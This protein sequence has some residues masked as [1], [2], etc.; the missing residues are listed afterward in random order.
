VNTKNVQE[1]S[2][3]VPR[4]LP[5]TDVRYWQRVLFQATYTHS[6]EIRHA[7]HWSVKLQYQGRRMTFA[8]GTPNK[9]SAASRARNIYLSLQGAGWPATLAKFKPNAADTGGGAEIATVGEFIAGVK[10]K[11]SV[12][13]RTLEG[14]AQAFR[15]IVADVQRIDGGKAKY[16]AIKGG[17]QKWLDQINIVSLAAIT[18]DLVQEWKL[19]FIR[20][21]GESPARQRSARTSANTILR[22]ARSLFSPKLLKFV[23]VR[24]PEPLPFAGVQFEPRSSMRYRSEVDAPAL[25]AAARSELQ[26]DHAEQFK[27]FLLGIMAGLRR[28]EIDLLEWS[29]LDFDRGLIRVVATRYFQ[30]KSEDS[31]GDVEVDQELLE[32]FRTYRAGTKGAFVIESQNAPRPQARYRHYRCDKDFEALATWLR[33]KGVPSKNPLHAMRKEFGSLLCEKGGIYAASRALRHADIR[34]TSAHYLD[35]KRRVTV[36]L[37]GLLTTVVSPN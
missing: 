5:K 16:D 29:S 37:G 32:I 24:L 31:L 21:A 3:A 14:Y 12:Q 36:G 27:I 8:L 26:K 10:A 25:V 18:P 28:R 4:V 7:P 19:G 6:G 17:R 13:G 9:A 33:S 20:A 34:T 30:P 35:R 23:R 22:N 1:V 15:K 2:K 11:A